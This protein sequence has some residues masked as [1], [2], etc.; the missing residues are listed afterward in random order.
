MHDPLPLTQIRHRHDLHHQTRPTGKMLR[1][2]PRARFGIILLPG[3]A[4][5]FPF[6]EDVLDEV[7]AEGGVDGGGLGFVGAGL[8]CDVLRGN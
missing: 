1:S 2:L 8:G 7:V 6:L 3:E 5:P 4:G